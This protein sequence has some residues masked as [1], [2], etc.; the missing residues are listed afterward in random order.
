M[1]INEWPGPEEQYCQLSNHY[2]SVIRLIKLVEDLPV[3][4]APIDTINIYHR[5]KNLSL[6]EMVTHIKAV[7]DADL[8]K[9]II[10]DEEGELM[11]GRHRIMKAMMLGHKSIKYVRFD[12]NP[13]PCWGDES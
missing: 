6:R 9:P 2:W 1:K 5:Y 11:D 8:S 12:E 13:T 7:N 10:L 3:R 4:S